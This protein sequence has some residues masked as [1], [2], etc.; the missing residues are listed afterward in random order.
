MKKIRFGALKA[1]KLR[2]DA[3]RGQVGFEDCI[4]AVQE[5]RL[6]DDIP[7]PNPAF[8]HQRLL[9]FEV[10]G[11]IY[12]APYVEDEEN[13]FLKTVYPS[14]LYNAIYLKDKSHE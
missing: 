11:Y 10:K 6:I 3:T 12:V 5:G 4:L 8:P 13:I 1:E 14:R 2:N 9:I 7:N